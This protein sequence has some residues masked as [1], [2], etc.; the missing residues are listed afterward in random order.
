MAKARLASEV[1]WHWASKLFWENAVDK[2]WQ[3]L[4]QLKTF[5]KEIYFQ[6]LYLESFCS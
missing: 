6:S 3:F 2:A 5:M 4:M 1:R